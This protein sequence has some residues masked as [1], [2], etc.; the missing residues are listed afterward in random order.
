MNKNFFTLDE[1]FEKIIKNTL[2]DKTINS[3]KSIT[4][5]WTNIV[6]EVTTTDG[7]YFFRFPRDDFW[8][9]TIVKDYE[10]SKFISGKT[11]FNTVKLNLFYDNGR[12]FSV[13]KKIPGTVLAD[14]MNTLTQDEVKAISNDIAKFMFQLHNIEYKPNE[15]FN[16]NNIGLNL[17]DFLD[18]LLNVHVSSK[19][20]CFWHYD[21]FS[22]KQHNCLVHGDL[23]SSNIL[24]DENNR[25]SA[26]I[27]FGF[28]GFGNPYFD[29]SRIIG[30]CPE[31]FK[32][33]IINSYENIS[34][35]GLNYPVLDNEIHIWNNIDNAYI[36]YMR[37]I[38][39]YE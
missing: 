22:K 34:N 30:R 20:K 12:P 28:G 6:F 21:E 9:R 27:D 36:N 38:G 17:T 11:D 31:N 3:I 13:H 33:E 32:K 1:D 23:N 14:K 7:N 37:G 8:I 10:F 29:I 4:T 39:I 5:G 2:P 16:I 35:S 18:E 24:L 19:D 25:V 26:I 15:I